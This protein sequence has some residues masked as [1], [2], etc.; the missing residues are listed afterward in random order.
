VTDDANPGRS[1][2]IHAPLYG[3]TAAT[4]LDGGHFSDNRNE[5]ATCRG[6]RIPG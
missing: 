3:A 1:R 4:Q 5:R 2:K 6:P